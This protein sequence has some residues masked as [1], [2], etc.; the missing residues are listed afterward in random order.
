MFRATKNEFKGLDYIKRAL[1]GLK[2]DKKIV[3]LAVEKKG[4]LKEFKT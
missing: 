3:I 1:Y 2:T 4:L